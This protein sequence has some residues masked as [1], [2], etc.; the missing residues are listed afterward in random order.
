MGICRYN[1]QIQNKHETDWCGQH[2]PQLLE[3]PVYDITTDGMT[4][5]TA[6]RKPGRP[7]KC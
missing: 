7:K 5:V 3:L 2:E 4:K 1:P 6:L